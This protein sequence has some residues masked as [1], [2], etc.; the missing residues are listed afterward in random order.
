MS[1]HSELGMGVVIDTHCHIG[2]SENSPENSIHG[3]DLIAGMDDF[4][5]THAIVLPLPSIRNYAGEHDAIAALADQHPGRIFGCIC[6]PPAMGEAEVMAETRRCVEQLGFVA[7]KFHPFHHG[8]GPSSPRGDV[9][10]AAAREFDLPVMSHTGS[11]TPWS[12][13]TQLIPA[14]RKYPEVTFIAAHS[15]QE[16]YADDALLAADICE[17]ILLDSAWTSAGQVAKFIRRLGPEKV[18]LST[19]LPPN[20]ATEMAKWR[21]LPITNQEREVSLHS[22]PRRL[23]K[24]DLRG[25][26][27]TLVSEPTRF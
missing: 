23:F 4:G 17:N 12:L 16:I 24:L 1:L 26:D 10:F 18:M 27:E 3:A 9:I 8:G 20:N 15:G 14:A 22:M 6:I 5:I 25:F 11:G 13:P 19:D 21:N 2:A 7:M